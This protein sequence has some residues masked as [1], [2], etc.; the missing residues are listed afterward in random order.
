MGLLGKTTFP[1]VLSQS[2]VMVSTMR[3][4]EKNDD[5]SYVVGLVG[6]EMRM[7]RASFLMVPS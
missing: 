6:W 2:V 3:H 5:M 4:T 7:S 1:K